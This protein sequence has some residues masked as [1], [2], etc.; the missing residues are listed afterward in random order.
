MNYKVYLTTKVNPST[1]K[2]GSGIMV[3]EPDDYT[4]AAVEEIKEKGYKVLAYL[5]I[6]TI[7]KERP[8]YKK[9]KFCGLEKLDDWPNE[10][11]ADVREKAWRDFVIDRAKKLKAKG[12]D[13]WWLD[14][15]DVYEYYKSTKMYVACNLLLTR[16]KRLG[17]YVMVNGGSEFFDYSLD[18]SYNISMVNGVTQEEVFSLIVSYKGDGKFSKQKRGQGDFYKKLLRKLRKKGIDI[19]LLEYTRSDSVRAEIKKWCKENKGNYYIARKV[20]L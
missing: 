15:L 8:W 7:E 10:L 4:A 20:N 11:Y 2:P 19:F 13:G 16:I 5:S 3:I 17:G 14:N 18:H 1:L 6:G 9:Y 12:F